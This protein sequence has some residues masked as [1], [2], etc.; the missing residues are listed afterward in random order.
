MPAEAAVAGGGTA[1]AGALHGLVIGEVTEIRDL[2][3]FKEYLRGVAPS[4]ATVG[5]RYL[6]KGGRIDPVEGPWQPTRA[7][8]IEFPS[9]DVAAA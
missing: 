5:G 1:P 3:P 2:E 7:V 9:W 6:T 4:L 8:L